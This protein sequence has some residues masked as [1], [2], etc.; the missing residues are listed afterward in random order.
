MYLREA[1]GE[2]E[3]LLPVPA[4]HPLHLGGGGEGGEGGGGG[5]GVEGGEGSKG[6]GVKHLKKRTRW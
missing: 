6:E 3:E 5:K 1:A 4:H 2:Y